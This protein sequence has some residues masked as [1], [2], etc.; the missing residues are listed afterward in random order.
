[1]FP[2]P[3]RLLTYL[4]V[5]P[6]PNAF[7]H[8]PGNGLSLPFPSI[9]PPP[10]MPAMVQARPGLLLDLFMQPSQTAYKKDD[11]QTGWKILVFAEAALAILGLYLYTRKNT[12]DSSQIDTT[13]HKRTGDS[14]KPETHI[15]I[16]LQKNGNVTLTEMR[17]TA[18][19]KVEV[20]SRE[21][22]TLP[23]IPEED[24]AQSL[25]ASKHMQ[26]LLQPREQSSGHKQ[27]ETP[28]SLQHTE[29]APQLL[30][31]SGKND[32]GQNAIPLVQTT[33]AAKVK[34]DP[35]EAIGNDIRETMTALMQKH[36]HLNDSLQC[37]NWEGVFGNLDV[38]L[39]QVRHTCSDSGF[40]VCKGIHA[41]LDRARGNFT[42]IIRD[43]NL[44]TIVTNLIDWLKTPTNTEKPHVNI[45]KTIVRHGDP[46]EQT[47]E[48]M[49]TAITGYLRS[50]PRRLDQCLQY[51]W[52]S[53]ME[54]AVET[55]ELMRKGSMANLYNTI[56]SWIMSY[57][58]LDPQIRKMT[59]QFFEP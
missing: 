55:A 12:L 45:A 14:P 41:I 54:S 15:P 32:T 17:N 57:M 50:N 26:N 52:K 34:Q 48:R 31:E 20:L 10:G 2:P 37:I 30:M 43:K 39:Q 40:L 7:S 53:L 25:P 8:Y 35:L 38:I 36:P 11:P 44:K 9:L 42:K 29:S 28:T 56:P 49:V 22:Q 6:A 23:E 47:V 19:D 16:A 24:R 4:P 51:D 58:I 13:S 18:S 33:K 5:S 21:Q 1:M 27:E 46:P 59:D 3:A